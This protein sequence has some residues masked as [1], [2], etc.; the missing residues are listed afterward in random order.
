[1]GN[2]QGSLCGDIIT[3]EHDYT[4]GFRIHPCDLYTPVSLNHSGKSIL[5]R[6]LVYLI[7]LCVDLKNTR[8]IKFYYLNLYR[9]LYS[10]A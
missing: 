2:S 9:L 10:V 5:H 7:R 3:V 8:S 1:M 4:I 6:N